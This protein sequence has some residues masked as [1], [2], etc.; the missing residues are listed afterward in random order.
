M[1]GIKLDSLIKGVNRVAERGEKRKRDVTWHK[2]FIYRLPKHKE[3]QEPRERIGKDHGQR[4]DGKNN[5]L[6]YHDMKHKQGVIW[7][8][9]EERSAMFQKPARKQTV[10]KIVYPKGSNAER[11]TPICTSTH[12]RIRS[13]SP[14]KLKVRIHEL[15]SRILSH[16]P[17]QH[18]STVRTSFGSAWIPRA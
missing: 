5:R 16:S 3:R 9:P 6:F 8:N 4:E 11:L 18:R 14:A 12:A 10:W 7:R 15:D 17:T 13:A 2:V 1:V